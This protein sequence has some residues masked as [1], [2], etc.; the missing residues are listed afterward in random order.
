MEAAKR[1]KTHAQLLFACQHAGASCAFAGAPQL[2][3]LKTRSLPIWL[4]L[5]FLEAQATSIQTHGEVLTQQS[6]DYQTLEACWQWLDNFMM[7]ENILK[8]CFCSLPASI[9][10]NQPFSTLATSAFPSGEQ[11]QTLRDE[12]QRARFFDNFARVDSS[13][14]WLCFS[15]RHPEKFR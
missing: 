8:I 6:A 7:Q 10:R 13:H 9:T 12:L 1:G 5:K 14:R 11:R 4:H 2:F 15:C 3:E